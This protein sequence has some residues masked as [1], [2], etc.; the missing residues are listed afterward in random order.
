MRVL[1]VV[2]PSRQFAG[3]ERVVH[4]LANFLAE[5]GSVVPTVYSF[6]N[7]DYG[8]ERIRYRLVR[9]RADR[10]RQAPARLSQFLRTES[11]DL[12]VVAQF[13]LATLVWL[14]A[15]A[16]AR[17]RLVAHL[18][19]NPQ[20]ERH[21][22]LRAEVLYRVF[23]HV[24]CTRLRGVL[25]VGPSLTASVQ[26]ALPGANCL[27]S[28]N[29]V[30]VAERSLDDAREPSHAFRYVS[31]GRLSKE[32][33][34]DL[35]IRAFSELVADRPDSELHLIGSGPEEHALKDLACKLAVA[36][37]VRFHGQLSN[38]FPT[39]A[40]CDCFVL[41]SRWEG[42]PLA[43]VEALSLGLGVVV[44]D[45]EFGPSDV[46]DSRSIGLVAHTE[47][48]DSLRTCMQEARFF[49]AS[50]EARQIRRDRALAF[51]PEQSGRAHLEIL[52]RLVDK[53]DLVNSRFSTKG[54]Q[55]SDSRV[56]GE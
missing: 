30:R 4:E 31:V 21:M 52:K 38:P 9:A 33:G 12:I 24:V 44:T 22:S 51:S 56:I 41:G 15:P 36:D 43:V 5:D 25:C 32:K 54:K 1:Y 55:L 26:R 3:I 18:H 17:R 29:P 2:P 6:A 28:P 27:F 45:C 46:V 42:F 39:M 49:D 50:T 53:K 7:H 8:G 11:F 23:S 48:V 35:V 10:L 20:V 14:A 37:R 40:R 16:T 19:G 47:S 34:H 13:E